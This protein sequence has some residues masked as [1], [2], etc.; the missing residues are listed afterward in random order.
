MLKYQ[1]ALGWTSLAVQ[2]LRICLSMQRRDTGLGHGFDLW[3]GTQV[4]SL[5]WEDST[6]CR[7]TKS[8]QQPLKPMHPEPSLGNEKLL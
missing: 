5:V 7:A 2:C 8:A 1:K 3:S 6:C 4:R